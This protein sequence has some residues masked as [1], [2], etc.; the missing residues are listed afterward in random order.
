MSK[1]NKWDMERYVKLQT[2][3]KKGNI[4]PEEVEELQ[5]MA[6]ERL[7]S[8]IESDPDVKAVFKRLKDR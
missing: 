4:T 6:L 7:F 2:A 5:H 3:R 1:K 8:I